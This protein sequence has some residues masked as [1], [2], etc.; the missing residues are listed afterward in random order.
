MNHS[1]KKRTLSLED[2]S[3]II[4]LFNLYE[5]KVYG[6]IQTSE[7][8]IQEMIESLPEGDR[9]G[10]WQK[11][12]LVA[13]SILTEKDHRLPSL[14]LALP[15][16]QMKMYIGEMVA[17]LL[18]SARRK[19]K[20]ISD[21]KTIILSANI[22][23]EKASYEEFGFLPTRYW[24]E[25]KKDLKDLPIVSSSSSY[26]IT[27]FNPDTETVSLHE[28]F[29]E[30]FSDHFDYHPSS[31]E[32]FK[33]RFLRSSFNPDLW[34][35][36]KEEKELVGFAFCTVNAETKLGEITHLGVRKEWRRKGLA[37]DLL[38]HSFST[39]KG[40]GMVS[41]A[42]LV[43]SDSYTDAI[44]VYQKAGMYVNRGFTRY[45]LEV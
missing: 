20:T 35:V 4:R 17:E 27:R 24:F 39:L 3:P 10:L 21:S 32:D 33:K 25:M 30:V 19:K 2:R 45:D 1:L 13:V 12:Q 37:H 34:F 6:E 41:V 29:E 5:T 36:L 22:K 28:V 7:C 40:E 31:L 18:I 8:E 43:D 23:E 16:T 9:T 38:Y 42:L 15:N 44:I 26:R 14:I 11:G